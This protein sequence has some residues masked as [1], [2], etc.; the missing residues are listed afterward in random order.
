MAQL[1]VASVGR[2]CRVARR[3]SVSK[4]AS[5]VNLKE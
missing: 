1:P 4:H 5:A 3:Q 2:H